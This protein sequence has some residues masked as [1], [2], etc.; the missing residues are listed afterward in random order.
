MLYCNSHEPWIAGFI[1]KTQDAFVLRRAYKPCDPTH[2][3][4]MPFPSG[5]LKNPGRY[6]EQFVKVIIHS[7][8]FEKF[9]KVIHGSSFEKFVQGILL[10]QPWAVFWSSPWLLL[11]KLTKVIHGS[12]FEQ[13]PKVIHGRYFEQFVKLIL[14]RYFEQFVKVIHGRY[15]EQLVKVI[16][17]RYFEQVVMSR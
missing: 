7:G 15:F 9:V 17:G 4:T 6:F 5:P 10:P 8:Y 2:P 12:Y 3:Y 1:E 11:E 14:G 13:F 16:H